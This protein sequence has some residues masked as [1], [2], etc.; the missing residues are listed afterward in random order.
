MSNQGELGDL[1]FEDDFLQ[2]DQEHRQIVSGSSAST[3]EMDNQERGT[4]RWSKTTK[5]AR[6]KGG[7]STGT[8]RLAGHTFE[9]KSP[10]CQD[11]IVRRADL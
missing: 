2:F 7:G 9:A 5:P 11:A 8:D 1:Y 4:K 10:D 3:S 6:R